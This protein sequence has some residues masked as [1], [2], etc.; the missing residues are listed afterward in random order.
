[1]QAAAI[2]IASVADIT[3]TE[4]PPRRLN[5]NELRVVV[6]C[7]M[8]TVPLLGRLALLLF[9]G[10]SRDMERILIGT[11]TERRVNETYFANRVSGVF[12]SVMWA[13]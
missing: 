10:V 5:R 8:Q 3:A 1:M 9:L 6:V 12:T 4:T 7:I 11:V 2:M 13:E